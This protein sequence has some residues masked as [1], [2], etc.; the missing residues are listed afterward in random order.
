[1]FFPPMPDKNNPLFCNMK[2]Y[3]LLFLSVAVILS[4]VAICANAQ[5]PQPLKQLLASP[6][7][8][9]ASIGCIVK[10]IGSPHAKVSHLADKR[11]TPASVLKTITTAT[12]LELLG[13]TYRYP[14]EIQYDGFIQNGILNGNIY[15]KGHGDPT[16]GSSQ[17]GPESKRFMQEWLN[18]IRLAGITK[19]NGRV[20]A[21]E[22]IFDTEGIS[23]KWLYEDLGSYY[24]AGSYGVNMFDNMYSLYLRSGEEGTSPHILRCD[25][26]IN[27]IF[28]NYLKAKSISKDSA[29]IV[30]MPFV[31]ERYLYGSIPDNQTNYKMKGDMPEPALF[32][33]QYLEKELNK[34]GITV[35]MPASCYRKMQEERSWQI[36]ERETLTTTYSP[37]LATI[38][39]KTNHVSHNL[40]A[41]ALLKTIGLRYKANMNESIS[42]FERGVRVMERFWEE[43]GIDMSPFVIYDGSG[44]ALANKVTANAL[45]SILGYMATQSKH[46]KAY[47]Q[48][49]P[50]AGLEGSVRNFL[51]GTSLA[52]HAWLKSGSMSKIRCYAGYIEN[53]GKQYCVVLLINDYEGNIAAV[54]RSLSRFLLGLFGQ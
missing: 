8:H 34:A 16:L 45:C 49:F 32:S 2:Q 53:Q 36:K 19:I 4:F 48:S 46:K 17:F 28:H 41:D 20:I 12:A 25:P 26:A 54:N 31:P 29:Y 37:T 1:M 23:M 14:T 30:G 44:L 43:K 39:E 3:R 38:I 52:G 27:I 5:Q 10:E 40:Y 42:S 7:M 51:K 6:E 33:A 22:S 24:G 11:L 21:D 47:L 15:I 13:E 50:Q 9:N 35:K 18:A